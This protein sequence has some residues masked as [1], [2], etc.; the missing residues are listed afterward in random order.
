MEGLFWRFR[1]ARL[2][3][4]PDVRVSR[5]AY[6]AKG[7]TISL[8][9]DGYPRGGGVVIEAGTRILQG[10]IISPYGGSIRIG[11]D[12][13]INPY[14]VVYGHGGLEIGDHTLIAAHTVII[15][16]NHSF[17]DR[18][19]TIASQPS[20]HLGIKI[21][22][23]VWIGCGVRVLDGVTIGK[24]CVVGAGAVVN[25]SLPDYAVAVGVPAKIIGWRGDRSGTVDQ[26]L[27]PVKDL[28]A[29]MG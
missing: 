7:A 18:E 3:R 19:K 8:D 11:K 16:S 23:D 12:V 10:S 2:N 17:V 26:S 9:L 14:C 21:G 15:P 27:R 20:I 24:G 13:S 4:M 6:V 29:A 25:R 22:E 1:W 5:E 28:K